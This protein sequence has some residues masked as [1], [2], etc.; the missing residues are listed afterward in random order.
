MR[1]T[2]IFLVLIKILNSLDVFIID[3]R[4]MLFAVISGIIVLMIPTFL[5]NILKKQ[6]GYIKYI[7]ILCSVIA[8]GILNVTLSFH[9]VMLFLYPLA[10]TCLYF[11]KN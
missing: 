4:V 1:I 3:D 11:E 5:V 6:N 2:C 9:V 8:V 10:L 7:I